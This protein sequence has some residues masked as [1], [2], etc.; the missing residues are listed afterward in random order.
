MD[1]ARRF[2]G[3]KFAWDGKEYPGREEAEQAAQGYRADGF[4]TE[5]AEEDGRFY[6]FTRRETRESAVEGQPL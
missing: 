1:L 6:V 4:G 3:K 2:G 5:T